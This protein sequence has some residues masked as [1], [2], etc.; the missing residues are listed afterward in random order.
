M[1]LSD[2]EIRKR[3]LDELYWDSSLDASKIQVTVDNGRVTLTG[4]APTYSAR[5]RATDAA[6]RIRD[7]IWVD[8]RITVRYTPPPP[9]DVSIREMVLD[10]LAANPDMDR[11]DIRVSAKKGIVTLEG[12]VDEYWKKGEADRIACRVRGVCDIV[13]KLTVVTTRSVADKA[14]ADDVRAALERNFSGS[15]ECLTIRVENGVV[16][17]SGT[18]PNWAARRAAVTAAEYTRGVLDVIDNLGVITPAMVKG[19]C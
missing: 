14:I 3:I 8:N 18:V 13:N 15:T 19:V 16:T 5:N 7:V 6:C 11:T 12:S 2:K 4:T 17:L 10:Y 9:A 1:A